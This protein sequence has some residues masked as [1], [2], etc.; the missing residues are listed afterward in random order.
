MK[1]LPFL[2][3]VSA[4]SGTGKTTVV[5]TVLSQVKNMKY[6]VSA[7][8]RECRSDETHG[9]SY[10]FLSKDEFIR[11]IDEGYFIEWAVIYGDFYGTPRPFIEECLSAGYDVILDL[12]I[13]G[14]RALERVFPHKVVSIFL[15]PPDLETLKTRLTKRRT[16][17]AEKLKIRL[18]L[19][20]N[21]ILWSKE[22][23]YI[24]LNDK[25][26]NAVQS[27]ISII[28]AERMKR[29]RVFPYFE[30]TILKDLGIP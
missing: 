20:K 8:T 15:M 2:V 30:K 26:D 10:I 28:I 25:I 18:N 1:H 4:P 22:Y 29:D 21:E 13:N 3:V 9:R 12:D 19:A 27:V 17:T 7:T 14:K 11:K 23:D 6:S 16:E 24:V 5:G